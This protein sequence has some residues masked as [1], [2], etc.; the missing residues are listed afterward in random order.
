[1]VRQENS[2]YMGEPADQGRVPL[3]HLRKCRNMGLDG[4][5]RALGEHLL[6]GPSCS[7]FSDVE[8][9]QENLLFLA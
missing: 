9:C 1:M 2:N 6:L 7:R 3:N 4:Y 5:S 8:Q